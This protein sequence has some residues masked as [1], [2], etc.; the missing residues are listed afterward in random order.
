MCQLGECIKIEQIPEDKALLAYRMWGAGLA[1]VVMNSTR[2]KWTLDKVVRAHANP[3]KNNFAGLY[4][5]KSPRRRPITTGGYIAGTI[6]IW[7]NIAIHEFGYRASHARI[8]KITKGW[9][10]LTKDWRY[11]SLDQAV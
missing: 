10:N 1:S 3:T 2:S 7:G 5:F 9:E 6:K 4:G 11:L 8:L